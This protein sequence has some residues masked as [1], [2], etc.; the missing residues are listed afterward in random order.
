MRVST[1][2]QWSRPSERYT[3]LKSTTLE[4][5]STVAPGIQPVRPEY[6]PKGADVCK[7]TRLTPLIF[8][9]LHMYC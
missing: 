4:R 8:F 6:V 3:S 9:I 2:T 1:S 7:S 5:E